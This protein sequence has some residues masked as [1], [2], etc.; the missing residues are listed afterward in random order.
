VAYPAIEDWVRFPAFPP[1]LYLNSFFLKEFF[2]NRTLRVDSRCHSR[3]L[4]PSV[5]TILTSEI[6]LFKR[7]FC[8]KRERHGKRRASS[9]SSFFLIKTNR[10]KRDATLQL[11]NHRFYDI[12]AET[13]SFCIAHIFSTEKLMKYFFPSRKRYPTSRI[14]HL[15]DDIVFMFL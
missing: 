7:I 4:S 11:F 9:F 6:L 15:Y 14:S 2:W 5:P 8:D 10:L 13:C 1:F 3:H 12:E